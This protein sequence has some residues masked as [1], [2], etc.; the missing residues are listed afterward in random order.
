MLVSFLIGFLGGVT[1]FPLWYDIPVR[2]YGNGL[3]FLY[4]IAAAYL[5][6]FRGIRGIRPNFFKGFVFFLLNFTAALVAVVVISLIRFFSGDPLTTVQFGGYGLVAFVTSTL[7][8]WSVPRITHLFER[9]LERALRRPSIQAMASLRDLP[10]RIAGC[11]VS[12]EIFRE[13]IDTLVESLNLK[14]ACAFDYAEIEGSYRC[15]FTR[16][17][18]PPRLSGMT[19]DGT[20]P[21]IRHLRQGKGALVLEDLLATE[22][23]ELRRNVL[24]LQRDC[25]IDL[26]TPIHAG[27]ELFGFLAISGPRQ[28]RHLSEDMIGLIG[29]IASQIGFHLRARDLERRT[30]EMDKLVALGTMAAGLAHELRNPLVS[31]KTFASLAASGRMEQVTREK[32]LEILQRDVGRISSIVEGVALFAENS[33]FQTRL[34]EVEDPV[35]KSIDIQRPLLAARGIDLQTDF[36]INAWVDANPGQLIQ[37]F[38]NLM[39]NAAQVLEGRDN[40]RIRIGIRTSGFR[41]SE[42]WVEISV[43]DNGPGVP[44]H[45]EKR[46]FE[47]FFSLRD[48]GSE[49]EDRGMGLGLALCKRIIESHRGLIHVRGATGGG[50]CFVV[51]L[52]MVGLN[53]DGTGRSA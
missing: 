27:A 5:I 35:R 29:A 6:H 30:G 20:H 38:D 1:N 7:L 47:P 21:L 17:S 24:S 36:R 9:A 46:I 40:P 3:V 12:G 14:G 43:A 16:G 31:V 53:Q 28:Q 15:I 39:I 42:Q 50:S 2:P 19:L 23:P 52:P 37:V 13:T 32:S 41:S 22:S 25:G 34:I 26:I 4:L 10:V 44:N 33:S 49:K 48:T 51:L 45:L 18:I 8:F 11:S